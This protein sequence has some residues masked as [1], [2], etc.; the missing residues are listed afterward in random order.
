M[1]PKQLVPGE[2]VTGKIDPR[3]DESLFVPAESRESSYWC[4]VRAGYAR[5]RQ[6]RVVIAGL[7][8]DIAPI[9]PWTIARIERLGAWFRDYRVVIYENDSADRTGE[10]LGDWAKSNPRVRILCERRSDPV[11]RPTRCLSRAVRMAYY[12]SQC[13]AEIV[14]RLADFDEVILVDT[15]LIGGWSYDGVAHTFGCCDWDFVG[16]YG[17]IYRRVGLSPNQLA[18]YDAWAFRRDAAFTPLTTKQVNAMLFERGQPLQPV[19][20]CFGGLGVYTMSAY[21]AGRYSGSDIEHVTFHHEMHR[22]GFYRTFLNP[23]QIALYGRKHRSW[24]RTFAKLIR[25]RNRLLRRPV[26]RWQFADPPCPNQPT[27]VV[28]G[29]PHRRAA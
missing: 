1:S 11:N 24:D 26:L 21:R 10:L 12:R 2:C 5:M 29:A 6:R 15:D 4:A 23:N 20:S 18:H 8:R 14:S 19:S 13:Q 7:A 3:F 22:R 28:P 27:N 9:L 17:V 16:A 25:L